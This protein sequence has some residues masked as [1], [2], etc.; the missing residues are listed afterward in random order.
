MRKGMTEEGKR[1]KDDKG[2]LHLQYI[3][4]ADPLPEEVDTLLPQQGEV[5]DV[6]GLQQVHHIAAGDLLPRLSSTS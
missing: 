2:G 6:G 1:V 3:G 5:V 4:Q